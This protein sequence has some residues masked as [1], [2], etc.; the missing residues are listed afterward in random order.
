MTCSGVRGCERRNLGIVVNGS[1]IG[2]HRLDVS[3]GC[4][5]VGTG[6]RVGFLGLRF[7]LHDG[8]DGATVG[9]PAVNLPAAD[10]PDTADNGD[11][12]DPAIDPGHFG[13][14]DSLPGCAGVLSVCRATP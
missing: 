8:L 2:V 9:V 1:R 10:K 4:D 5:G 3:G 12:C 6:D 7:G 13:V 14:S 11:G